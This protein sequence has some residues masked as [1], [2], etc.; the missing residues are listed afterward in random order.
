MIYLKLFRKVINWSFWLHNSF[1]Q[2]HALG[3]NQYCEVISRKGF[4][5]AALP[6]T[7]SCGAL[8]GFELPPTPRKPCHGR[9]T[10]REDEPS[11]QDHNRPVLIVP[12]IRSKGTSILEDLFLMLSIL[13]FHAYK[14]TSSWHLDCEKILE[15][16]SCSHEIETILR[17]LIYS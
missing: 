14:Y 7:S 17:K 9:W 10:G 8:A 15:M 5:S 3:Y 4:Q 1:R 2:L 11:K 12:G 13:K 16:T 6:Q